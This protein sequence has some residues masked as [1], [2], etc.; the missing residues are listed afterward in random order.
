[1]LVL[2]MFEVT[3]S[4]GSTELFVNDGE[5]SSPSA[6][7]DENNLILPPREIGNDRHDTLAVSII[8]MS[9]VESFI[10]MLAIK[11]VDGG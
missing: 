2:V 5:L 3:P 1:M 7:T 4:L 8:R 9:E 10:I 6:C 11:V